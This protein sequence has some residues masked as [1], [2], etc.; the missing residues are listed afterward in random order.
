MKKG[1]LLYFLPQFYIT[2]LNRL[3]DEGRGITV[4]DDIK[5]G[6]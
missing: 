6:F 2:A 1:I 4:G 3:E 5:P